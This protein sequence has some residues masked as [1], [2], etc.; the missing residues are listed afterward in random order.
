MRAKGVNF[1]AAVKDLAES[2]GINQESRRVVKT[3]DYT[4]ENGNLL[5]HTLGRRLRGAD[6]PEEDRKDLLG[7]EHGRSITT[8]YSMAEIAK[9]IAYSNR[10]CRED[11]HK[12]DTIVFPE[13]RNRQ[14]GA[15]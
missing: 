6:V 2:C 7:H 15:A 3:Y 1:K 5:K 10:I 12:S 4:D 8:H 14:A 9:L 11:C 13:K